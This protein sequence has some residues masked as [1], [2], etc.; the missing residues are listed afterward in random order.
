[1]SVALY[2]SIISLCIYDM[3]V[4]RLQLM[5]PRCCTAVSCL[6]TTSTDPL[7]LPHFRSIRPAQR[8]NGGGVASVGADQ[9]GNTYLLFFSG[10]PKENRYTMML[11]LGFLCW[12]EQR[13]AQG[14]LSIISMDERYSWRMME[15]L[16]LNIDE[17][18]SGFNEFKAASLEWFECWCN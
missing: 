13:P 15:S 6:T 16:K 2:G 3:Y 10:K 1:M 5:A 12:S 8:M 14:G 4:R 18:E 7:G 11:C 17:Q 9:K